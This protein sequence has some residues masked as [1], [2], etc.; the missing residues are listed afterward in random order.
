M[1]L[2]QHYIY[3]ICMMPLLHL[4]CMYAVFTSATSALYVCCFYLCYLCIVC[5]LFLPLLPLHCMYAVFTSATSA[6]YV[7]Q[8]CLCMICMIHPVSLHC[9]YDVITALHQHDLHDTS[10]TCA[11]YVCCFYSTRY[12]CMI[13]M[14][15]LLVHGCQQRLFPVQISV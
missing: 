2:L 7:L 6:L 12:L 14:L 10:A 5:M 8:H 9:V 4:H 15:P 11:L 3:M 13:C 1:M